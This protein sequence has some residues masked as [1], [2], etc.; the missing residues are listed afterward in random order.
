MAVRERSSKA[1]STYPDFHSRAPSARYKAVNHL[2]HEI[3]FVLVG[4]H[5]SVGVLTRTATQT[6][7]DLGKQAHEL[8]KAQAPAGHSGG[9]TA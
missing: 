5:T 6:L 2:L 7:M 3:E 9:R 1:R 4:M 8:S